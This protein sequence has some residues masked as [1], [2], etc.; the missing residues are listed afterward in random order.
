M[1]APSTALY[2]ERDPSYLL[3]RRRMIGTMARPEWDS[4]ALRQAAIDRYWGLAR[5]AIRVEDEELVSAALVTLYCHPISGEVEFADLGAGTGE[6]RFISPLGQPLR[7]VP[8]EPTGLN[9]VRRNT[10]YASWAEGPLPHREPDPAQALTPLEDPAVL[11]VVANN[12][13][14]RDVIMGG[15]SPSNFA[16]MARPIPT[17]DHQVD[18]RIR[19]I[20]RRRDLRVLTSLQDRELGSKILTSEGVVE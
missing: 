9:W 15:F 3:V 7:Q 20:C 19:G 1:P 17:T 5:A 10:T 2:V 14:I 8:V 4:P 13:A 11:S 6:H 18:F 16:P 12:S